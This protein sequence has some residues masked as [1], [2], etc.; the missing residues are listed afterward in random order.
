M[1]KLRMMAALMAGA[2][3]SC[4]VPATN[5]YF[6][7]GYGPVSKGMAGACV[8]IVES[9]MCAANN[10]ATLVGLDSRWEI[11]A[12]L[13]A[14]DRGFVADGP[15]P[16][17]IP[18]GK[19][20][21]RNKLFLIPHFAY[22]RKLDADTSLGFVLGGNGGM[23]TDY[24]SAVWRR[25]PP[26]NATSPTGINLMQLFMGVSYGKRLNEQHSVAIMPVFAIQSLEVKG[27]QPFA[28]PFLSVSPQHVTNNGQNWSY[29]GGLRVGWLYQPTDRLNIG[30]SYQS[31]LWMTKFD[32]YEGLL[33]HGGNF[34]IPPVLDLGFAY[35]ITP[36]WT[37][38]L[39]Y[40]RIWYGDV[41]SLSNPNDLVLGQPGTPLLGADNGLGFGWG[42]QNIYKLGLRW[43]Y[44]PDLVLRAGYSH[45]DQ[46]VPSAQALFNILA[47]AVVRDHYTLGLTKK[48]SPSHDISVALMY[49]PETKVYGTNI[50][51]GPQ[52]G[53][54]FMS[55]WDLEVG[56][57]FHL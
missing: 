55:Q 53:H 15:E 48:L 37:A 50:N 14:P 57:V 33:A 41:K 23:N 12:D 31:R 47:P 40:Q 36:A 6:S 42:N 27:L 44:S 29:G 25:F 9:A 26:N 30:A 28:N 45:N 49:A 16:A 18:P 11:G 34:D 20:D 19:Y 17:A 21:S 52:T 54:L 22:N 56:W 35:Q 13:F 24:D 39:A 2:V 1:H 51:T 7:H 46:V 5:G 10:P 4:E 38:S 3:V 43:Q 32:K 8:A